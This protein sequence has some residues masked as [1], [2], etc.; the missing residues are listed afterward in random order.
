MD[1]ILHL[2]TH[3]SLG[4]RLSG[5]SPEHKRAKVLP[6]PFS[7]LCAPRRSY[8]RFTEKM[9][10]LRSNCLIETPVVALDKRRCIY[11]VQIRK[12]CSFPR[13]SRLCST[14]CEWK[15]SRKMPLCVNDHSPCSRFLCLTY[16]L[17]PNY[18]YNHCDTFF[19][20]MPVLA[21]VVQ[22]VEVSIS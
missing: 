3:D 16:F 19:G 11:L 10:N 1:C 18:T 9:G 15:Y 5:F 2:G 7:F 17:I 6:V 12:T 22:H 4:T 13:S 14:L 20:C 8:K 21:N